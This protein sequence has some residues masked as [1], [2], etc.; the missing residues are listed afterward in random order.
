MRFCRS[1]NYRQLENIM[2]GTLLAALLMI[3]F[4]FPLRINTYIPENG[5]IPPGVI[6]FI[7]LTAFLYICLLILA[8]KHVSVVIWI[9]EKY[10]VSSKGLTRS[11][12]RNNV[13]EHLWSEF[14]EIAICKLHY[15]R[16][17]PATVIRCVIGP[18]SWG[19]SKGWGRW[20]RKAYSFKN[21]HRII[22]ID[23]S[24][25]ILEEFQQMCPFEIKDYR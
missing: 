22:L 15:V 11:S 5:S 24:D 13:R 7:V 1:A 4:G 18:E 6:L 17:G 14:T 10:S 20:V 12:F 8:I 16:G 3:T 9:N 2:M 23:H 19:P 21:R 25:E